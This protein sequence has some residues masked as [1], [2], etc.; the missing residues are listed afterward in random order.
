VAIAD[1]LHID[2]EEEFSKNI[3]KLEKRVKE[4]DGEYRETI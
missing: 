1:E 4:I 2:L 3:A